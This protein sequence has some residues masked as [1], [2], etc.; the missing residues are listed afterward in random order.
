MK[1][2]TYVFLLSLIYNASFAQQSIDSILNYTLS[3]RG[4]TADDITIPVNFDKDKS[5]TNDSKLLLPVV[6]DIMKAP[7]SS[8]GFMDS[9]ITYKDSDLKPLIGKMFDLL[10]YNKHK[11]ESDYPVVNIKLLNEDPEEF[12]D[13]LRDFIFEVRKRDKLLLKSFSKDDKIYLSNYL[14]SLISES[15][16]EG[17]NNSDIFAFNR[18]RDSS[19]NISRKTMDILNKVDRLEI[20]SNSYFNFKF[21]P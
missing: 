7:L 20:K 18:E 15:E 19:M 16:S 2:F 10:Y 21:F 17:G 9:V 5:P 14:M 6:R 11:S 8:F 1:L 13:K 3:Y 12:G 4:L